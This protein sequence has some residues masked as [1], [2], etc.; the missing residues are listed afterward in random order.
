MRHKGNKKIVKRF[1][2]FSGIWKHPQRAVNDT[3]NIQMIDHLAPSLP[4]TTSPDLSSSIFQ[5]ILYNI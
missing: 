5:L 1:S 4:S 3:D 2:G